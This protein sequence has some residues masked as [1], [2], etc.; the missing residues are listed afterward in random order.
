MKKS[1][2]GKSACIAILAALL[3]ISLA[4][5]ILRATVFEYDFFD[6]FDYGEVFATIA[7][8][9]LLIVL[10]LKGKDRLFYVICGIWLG[11]FVLCQFF[12]LP[13]EIALLAEMFTYLD[14][15]SVN[16]GPTIISTIVMIIDM[17]AIIALGALLIKYIYNGKAHTKTFGILCLVSIL[18]QVIYSVLVIGDIIAG[19]P[20]YF[21][22][23]VLY[24]LSRIATVCLLA[25]FAHSTAKLHVAKDSSEE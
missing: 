5:V 2:T 18:M 8:T 25:V 10:A 20:S 1:L 21:V 9:T 14:S 7:I 23:S 11:Y 4:D 16:L 24:S 19:M 13:G 6:L 15:F 12:A 17:L 22:L 3:V